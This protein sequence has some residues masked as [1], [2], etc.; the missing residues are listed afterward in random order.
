MKKLTFGI[1]LALAL[2]MSAN[3]SAAIDAKAATAIMTKAACNACHLPDKKLVG[4]G[5]KDVAAKYKA[6]AKA[7]DLLMQKVRTGGAGIW[8]PIPMP[9]NPKE[10]ISDEDLKSLIGWILTL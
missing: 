5:Y 4:P 3:A 8:G 2:G 1:A 10:K 7:S 6:D 9:P